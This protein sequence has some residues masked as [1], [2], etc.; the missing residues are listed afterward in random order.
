M[1]LDPGRDLPPEIYQFALTY[2]IAQL[3]AD[4]CPSLS[5]D[6]A[7][8]ASVE[9]ALAVEFAEEGW[10]ERMVDDAARNLPE[11]RIAADVFEYIGSNNVVLTEPATYCQ[12]GAREQA[13]DTA[14]GALLS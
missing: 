1:D 12:A 14:I 9:Q 2:G 8:I 3:L 7:G 13:R 6:R 4:A 5:L 10:T 11:E